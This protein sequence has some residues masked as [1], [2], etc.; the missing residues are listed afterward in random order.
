[1]FQRPQE[2]LRYDSRRCSERWVRA[3]KAPSAVSVRSEGI[4]Y[5]AIVNAAGGRVADRHRS[6]RRVDHKPASQRTH[7]WHELGDVCA[8]AQSSGGW[9]A[10]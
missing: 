4:V 10:A 3:A 2:A 6:R 5:F 8:T 1:M 7:E 9:S